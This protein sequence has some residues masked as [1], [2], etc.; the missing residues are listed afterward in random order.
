VTELRTSPRSGAPAAPDPKNRASFAQEHEELL[1]LIQQTPAE[2]TVKGMFIS[3]FLDSLDRGGFPRPTDARFVSFK[4]YPL[5]QFMELM[6]VAI[7]TAWPTMSPRAGLRRLGQSAYPT[8][9][10]SVVGR[11]LF[12]V[13]GLNFGTALQLTE[14][15][16]KVSLNPGSAKLVNLVG[17]T[18]TLEF[19]D[20]WNFADCYQVGVMEGAMVAYRVKGEVTAQKLRRP[21]DVDLHLRWE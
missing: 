5:R 19:R 18:A 8:L 14:K 3:S 1:R 4:D 9:A 17:K 12:S 13:A 7:G 16:Y 15:A 21:C 11:V 20:I 2:A 6:L 10:A